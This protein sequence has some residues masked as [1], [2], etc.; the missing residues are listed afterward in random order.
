MATESNAEREGRLSEV[1]ENGELVDFTDNQ[2]F[3]KSTDTLERF[4]ARK[5]ALAHPVRYA[6]LYYLFRSADGDEDE[7]LPRTELKRLL[8]REKNGLQ[9]H[10]R[11]LLK[12]NLLAEVP[13]PDGADGRQTFYRI[14]NLGER[15]I[16]SDLWN[17]EGELPE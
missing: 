14:T 5:R 8:D 11:P 4:T 3:G 2:L 15:A 12:A 6:I 1:P 16:R 9:T 17:V 10:V 13:A 7:R